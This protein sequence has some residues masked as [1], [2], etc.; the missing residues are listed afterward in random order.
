MTPMDR[1]LESANNGRC[2]DITISGSNTVVKATGGVNADHIGVG[3]VGTCG[4][5]TIKAG[6]TVNDK[7]YEQDKIGP[8]G[9]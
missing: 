2:G 4:T 8:V 6:V 5:V 3:Y 7:K 1:E 9:H